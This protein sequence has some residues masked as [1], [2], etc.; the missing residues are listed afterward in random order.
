[1][2]P[3]KLGKNLLRFCWAFLGGKLLLNCDN[4]KFR[5][6]LR[7]TRSMSWDSAKSLMIGVCLVSFTIGATAF[8]LGF[9]LVLPFCGLEAAF[10]CLA[11]YLVQ[12]AGMAREVVIIE[13]DFLFL[14]SGGREMSCKLAA[15]KRWVTVWLY[16]PASL[17]AKSRLCLRYAGREIELGQF[18]NDDEKKKFAKVL[19]NAV[20]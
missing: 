9:P 18:L 1:M 10:F 17:T 6:E 5:W 16:G 14:E 4:E 11:F 3:E 15:N 2:N 19:I 8:L 20:H 13:N 12:S 7:P